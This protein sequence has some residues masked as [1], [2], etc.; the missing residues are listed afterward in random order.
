MGNTFIS[1]LTTGDVILGGTVRADKANNK[2]YLTFGD[3]ILL[4]NNKA[5]Y[6]RDSNS[7]NFRAIVVNNNNNA[8]VFSEYSGGNLYVGSGNTPETVIKGKFVQLVSGNSGYDVKMDNTAFRP[9]QTGKVHC[10][11]SSMRWLNG[12]WTGTL[13]AGSGT[14]NTSDRK[15]KNDISDI[16]VDFA[17]DFIMDLKPKTYKFKKDGESHEGKRTK[18]GFIA[19]DTHETGLKLKKDLALYQAH[20]VDENGELSYYDDSMTNVSDE[21]LEW[22]M[23]YS[24]IHAPHVRLTQDHENRIAKLEETVAKQ[25]DIIKQ[26][27]EIIKLLQTQLGMTNSENK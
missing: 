17:K 2:T 14:I 12:Y 6:C 18:M 22:G 13:Y 5:L 19:Q 21:N 16:E 20:I 27:A 1:S 23:D 24:Q 4:E 7:A 15:V 9:S 26:Q 8:G 10:G 11:Y 3:P 25:E